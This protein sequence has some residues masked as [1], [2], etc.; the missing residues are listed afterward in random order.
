M[1]ADC[2]IAG[3]VASSKAAAAVATRKAV[4]AVDGQADAVKRTELSSS[5]EDVREVEERPNYF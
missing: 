2:I 1:E 4:D 5:S 3:L